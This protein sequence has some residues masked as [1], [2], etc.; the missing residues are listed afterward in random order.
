M[1]QTSKA[2]FE[3]KLANARKTAYRYQTWRGLAK[4]TGLS[5]TALRKHKIT[6]GA[7]TRQSSITATP[8]PKI[9]LSSGTGQSTEQ[10]ARVGN[11]P[12]IHG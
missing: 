2:I 7:K 3:Q 1:P 5:E 9:D 12:Y 8:T 11:L 4:G 10:P 6:P